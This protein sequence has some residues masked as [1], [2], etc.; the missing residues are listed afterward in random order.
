MILR[1]D[2]GMKNGADHIT[3]F[4]VDLA[5]DIEKSLRELAAVKFLGARKVPIEVALRVVSKTFNKCRSRSEPF[6]YTKSIA[7]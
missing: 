6:A 1:Y 7:H 3:A 4:H 2:F 5:I